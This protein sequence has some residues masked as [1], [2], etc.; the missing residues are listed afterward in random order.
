[1][2][3]QPHAQE[4]ADAKNFIIIISMKDVVMDKVPKQPTTHTGTHTQLNQSSITIKAMTNNTLLHSRKR[5]LM[6]TITGLKAAPRQCQLWMMWR[7][8][9]PG[10]KSRSHCPNQPASIGEHVG[11]PLCLLVKC[12]GSG[13]PSE[14][15]ADGRSG[16]VRDPCYVTSLL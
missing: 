7:F 6:K 8:R 3:T 16:P 10:L 15:Q 2:T 5:H 4:N 9:C 1:L 13:S 12:E 14:W 11:C